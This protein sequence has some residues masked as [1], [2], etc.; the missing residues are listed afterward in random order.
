MQPQMKKRKSVTKLTEKDT[1]SASKYA[2]T[3]QQLDSEGEV[4]TKIVKVNTV[5]EFLGCEI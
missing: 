1:K 4:S 5:K 2:M 3:T